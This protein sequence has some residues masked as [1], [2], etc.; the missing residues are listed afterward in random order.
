M[1]LRSETSPSRAGR[2]DQPTV[3]VPASSDSGERSSSELIEA[4]QSP[5]RDPL[6]A[7]DFGDGGGSGGAEAFR[8]TPRP[9]P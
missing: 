2:G 4:P 1:A 8:R 6:D 3:S 9:R 5:R 7:H